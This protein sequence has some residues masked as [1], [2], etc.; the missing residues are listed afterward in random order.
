M[1]VLFHG[2]LSVAL[3]FFLYGH[4]SQLDTQGSL[5]KAI[6]EIIAHT[7]PDLN[8]NVKV[9]DMPA[10]EAHK[11]IQILHQTNK[12][13][14]EGDMSFLKSSPD[15]EGSIFSPERPIEPVPAFFYI[16]SLVDKS[17]EEHNL[18]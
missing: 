17:L 16:R 12:F 5:I 13:P 9:T 18:D 7:T 1:S 3:C 8:P 15:L 14:E 2:F 6:F 10:I 11:I 4:C